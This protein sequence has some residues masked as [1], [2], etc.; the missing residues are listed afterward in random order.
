MQPTAHHAM[1][2]EGS[3]EPCIVEARRY[4]EKELGV[5]CTGNPDVTIAQYPEDA[6]GIEE[7]RALKARA[8][9]A[10]FGSAQVFI[11]VFEA[12][13]RPAQNALLKL[14]EE[15]A[16]D[17]YFILIVP[18]THIL[19]P[20]VRSRVAYMG[21]HV[22]ET[23]TDEVQRFL[24]GTPA[25]RSLMIKH[26]IKESDRIRARKFCDALEV[27]Y[28]ANG[29]VEKHPDALREVMFVR[30]YITDPSSSPKMLLEHLVAVL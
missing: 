29:G 1:V 11:L 19:L 28:R 15:P 14:L 7:A 17:T 2:L 5:S 6:Y 30:S 22:D 27:Y 24:A 16:Q 8:T 10:P 4:V 25:E 21:R 26:I 9:Q 13:T 20:T 18:N 3:V 23:N 12:I